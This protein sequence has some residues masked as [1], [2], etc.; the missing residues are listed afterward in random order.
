MRAQTDRMAPMTAKRPPLAGSPVWGTNLR[1]PVPQSR[2][3]KWIAHA[4]A[5]PWRGDGALQCPHHLID[6]TAITEPG[7]PL[8]ALLSLDYGYHRSGWFANS[9]YEQNLH[10]SLS[11]PR[12]ELPHLWTPGKPDLGFAGV[13]VSQ[14]ETVSDDE[15]RA[16]GRAVFGKHCTKAWFEA[17]ASTFDPYRMPN[18]VHLRLFLERDSLRPFVPEGEPYSLRPWADGSSPAKIV[19]GR[20]GADVR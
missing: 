4:Y 11:H 2:L 6:T 16:W 5:H 8:R 18:V 13:P 10:I 1:C 17:A 9:D 3:T 7:R 20:L 12:P 19:D 14:L 15:A